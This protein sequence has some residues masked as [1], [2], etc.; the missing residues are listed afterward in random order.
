M[1]NKFKMDELMHNEILLDY[2]KMKTRTRRDD[3]NFIR[4]NHALRKGVTIKE[5]IKDLPDELPFKEEMYKDAC[6]CFDEAALYIG[7]AARNYN[8]ASL[9][10]EAIRKA[11][12]RKE[13]PN[14]VDCLFSLCMGGGK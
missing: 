5:L 8:S 9:L 7:A 11:Q 1:G 14:F 3:F 13:N 6:K 10:T 2:E 4:A 12:A